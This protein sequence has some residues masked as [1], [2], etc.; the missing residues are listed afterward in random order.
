MEDEA[1]LSEEGEEEGMEGQLHKMRI[2][3]RSG[4]WKGA[5]GLGLE[6]RRDKK[7]E[8]RFQ[9]RNNRR[10]D[11]MAEKEERAGRSAVVMFRRRY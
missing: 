1:G 4:Q 10:W 2:L 9:G 8:D 3:K 5:G 6:V 7:G 11:T